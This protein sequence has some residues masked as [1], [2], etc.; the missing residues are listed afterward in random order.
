MPALSALA[1]A[2]VVTGCGATTVPPTE[3]PTDTSVP[4]VPGQETLDPFGA[5]LRTEVAALVATLAAID[6]ALG[7]AGAASDIA[8]VHAAAERA[9]HALTTDA[10]LAGDLDDDGTVADPGVR[11]LFAGPETGSPGDDV[12]STILA[13]A[14]DEGGRGG[15]VIDVLRDPVTGDLSAWEQDPGGQLAAVMAAADT[16]TEE[17]IAALPGHLPRALAWAVACLAA[18]DLDAATAAAINGRVHATLSLD[19]AEALTD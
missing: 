16:G 14:R 1:V 10:E 8:G 17:A 6:A 11:P 12:L 7:D 3:G 9:V 2:L 13:A 15:R 19:A 5:A 4:G 18:D